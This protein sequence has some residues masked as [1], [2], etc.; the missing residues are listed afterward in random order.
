MTLRGV[1]G[2]D[3]VLDKI[4]AEKREGVE[5]RKL[6]EPMAALEK[7]FAKLDPQWSLTEAITSPRGQAP[8]GA[9]VQII[10]EIKKASPSKGMLAPDLDHR[11]VAQA[12]AAG[13]AAG[14]SVLTEENYFLGSLEWMRDVR[15]LLSA[16]GSDQRP[17][18]LRKD[19]IVEPYELTQ[20]RAYGADNVL[21][22]V[23][24]LEPELLRDLIMQAMA[25]NLEPLV[26]VHNEQ[27]AERAVLAG[28]RLIGVNNRDLHTFEVDLGVT[29][30]I[31]PLLPADAIVVGESGVRNRE[32]VQRLHDAGARAILVGEAFMKSPDLAAKMAELRI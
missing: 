2:T 4:V 9:A 27:E 10:A 32:D 31:R 6:Q 30:R 8:A 11:S 7:R 16:A 20:A 25:L 23:A 19:F 24:L 14:I 17:S 21:L 3:S 22:I 5:K 29:E 1:T 26:E 28:A 18:I 15:E 13:G 12:Y